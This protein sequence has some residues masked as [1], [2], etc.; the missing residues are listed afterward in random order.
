MLV[1]TGKRGEKVCIGSDITFTVLE[2]KGNRVRI[3]IDAP[4]RIPS[5]AANSAI[6]W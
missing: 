4:A 5:F 1:L 6:R 3:G 2:A